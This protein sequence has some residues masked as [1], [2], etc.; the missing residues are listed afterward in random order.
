[1]TL[2]AEVLIRA[3][4]VVGASRLRVKE[5]GSGLLEKPSYI[6]QLIGYTVKYN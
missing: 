2:V 3:P 5:T 4:T 1:M 6:C